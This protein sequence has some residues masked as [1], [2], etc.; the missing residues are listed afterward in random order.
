MAEKRFFFQ[1]DKKGKVTR[2]Q[3]ELGPGNLVDV[4]VMIDIRNDNDL[5]KLMIASTL[6]DYK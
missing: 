1:T 5:I 4:K 3:E 2:M 6:A